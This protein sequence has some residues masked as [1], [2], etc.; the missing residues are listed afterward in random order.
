MKMKQL[1]W[2]RTKFTHVFAQN[3]HFLSGFNETINGKNE[4]TKNI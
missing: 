3:T 4:Q 2:N 1:N